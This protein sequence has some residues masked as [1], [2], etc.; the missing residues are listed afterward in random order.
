MKVANWR[1]MTSAAVIRVNLIGQELVNYTTQTTYVMIPGFRSVTVVLFALCVGWI[2][3]IL[4][5]APTSKNS[6]SL[7][8]N[9]LAWF[10]VGPGGLRR[11][12]PPSKKEAWEWL[13]I[14]ILF[15]T[16]V[17]VRELNRVKYF[18]QVTVPLMDIAL[19]CLSFN[20]KRHE[21]CFVLVSPHS[22]RII[23][24]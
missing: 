4:A 13:G 14:V 24:K 18:F 22:D 12:R 23:S 21:E 2:S 11:H 3:S 17:D 6:V 9:S 1:L 20:S 5:C 16:T 8:G 19:R 15:L 10:S 7:V